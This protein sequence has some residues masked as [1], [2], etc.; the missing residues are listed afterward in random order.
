[1]INSQIGASY[2]MT[3]ALITIVNFNHFFIQPAPDVHGKIGDFPCA[4]FYHSSCVYDG[5][6]TVTSYDFEKTLFT[7]LT[8]KDSTPQISICIRPSKKNS[9]F[10]IRR[11]LKCKCG[12]RFLFFILNNQF[13]NNRT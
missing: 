1:V 4:I 3:F 6:F 2:W 7:F 10:L 8:R 13:F 9:R 12:G 5:K 11:F